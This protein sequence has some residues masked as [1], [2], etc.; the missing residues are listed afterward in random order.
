VARFD[1]YSATIEASQNRVIEAV[2]ASL[3]PEIAAGADLADERARYGYRKALRVNGLDG[4]LVVMWSDD[5]THVQASGLVADTVAW[6]IRDCW[7]VHRVSRA[8]VCDDFRGGRGVFLRLRKTCLRIA[9]ER[10]VKTSEIRSPTISDDGRTLYLGS[11]SSAVRARL[12][13]KGL[14]P[15]ASEHGIPED[16]VRLEFQVRPNSR[17][18]ISAALQP[19]NSLAAYSAWSA[20]LAETM[21]MQPG[22]RW[23]A[24]WTRP[25]RDR[26]A[27]NMVRQ[28]GRLI[29][30]M[31]REYDDNPA[32]LH[33]YLS[34]LL[35][36]ARSANARRR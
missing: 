8:D 32:G 1:W 5:E 21:A 27:R 7:P 18:K 31:L 26:M 13:E 17:D 11:P 20:H 16:V 33:R 29:A 12:Y 15:D 3:P 6:T 2:F 28:Y 35:T 30:Q 19:P 10:G 9:R 36:E 22:E 24:S 4:N 25:D 34:D 14:H 23:R